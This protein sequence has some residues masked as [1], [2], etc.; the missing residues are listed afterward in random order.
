MSAGTGL[1]FTQ[2]A[3]LKLKEQLKQHVQTL[4]KPRLQLDCLESTVTTSKT[5]ELSLLL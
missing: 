4:P 1:G 5:M 2:G 3:L